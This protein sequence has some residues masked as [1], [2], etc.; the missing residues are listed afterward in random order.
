MPR[1]PN[2]DD[3]TVR[4]ELVDIGTRN[5]YLLRRVD[6]SRNYRRR[7]YRRRDNWGRDNWGR[8]DARA[9]DR[10]SQDTTDNTTDEARPKI[11]PSMSP[12]AMVMMVHRR[13]RG[14]MMHHRS[15]PPAKATVMAKAA[16][17][18]AKAWAS[19]KR[20][21]RQNRANCKY[22]FLVHVYLS[23]LR[24]CGHVKIGHDTQKN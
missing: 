3:S 14:A 1:L 6:W 17:R 10:I 24:F 18:T 7:N 4:L 20:S 13:R 9:D 15:R 19:H 22:E 8:D 16:T 2:A 11:T 21:R 5:P 12:P 23:F